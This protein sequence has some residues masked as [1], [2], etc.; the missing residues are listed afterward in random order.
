M[1]IG[2]LS[3]QGL[4]PVSDKLTT[5]NFLSF[6]KDFKWPEHGQPLV[7][8]MEDLPGKYIEIDKDAYILGSFGVKVVD[9]KLKFL[10]ASICSVKKLKPNSTT[11]TACHPAD[12]CVVVNT[13]ENHIKWKIDYN[14]VY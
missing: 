7:Y 11:G 8:T 9:G 13:S 12:V 2:T 5:E 14:E 6:W 4:D 10:P 3:Y 1:G